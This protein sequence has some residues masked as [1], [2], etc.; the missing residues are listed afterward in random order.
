MRW[1]RIGFKELWQP[2]VLII[3]TSINIKLMLDL[4]HFFTQLGDIITHIDGQAVPDTNAL[5]D[6]LEQ[7]QIGTEVTVT[8]IRNDRRMQAKVKLQSV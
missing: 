5:L 7:H 6:V 4:H 3:E 1:Y 8:F 2:V